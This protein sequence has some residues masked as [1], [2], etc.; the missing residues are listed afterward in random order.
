MPISRREFERGQWDPSRP[1]LELFFSDP[2]RAYTVDDVVKRLASEGLR[3]SSRRVAA[4][5]RSLEERGWIESRV[6]GRKRYY[7]RIRLGFRR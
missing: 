4:T 5:L 6:L 3:V 1:V 7:I 2:D